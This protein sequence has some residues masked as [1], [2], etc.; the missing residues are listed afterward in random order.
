M[1]AATI[2]WRAIAGALGT[3]PVLAWALLLLT[4]VVGGGCGRPEP[5]TS[6]TAPAPAAATARPRLVSLAPNLTEIVC[7]VG[8]ADQLVGRTS[9]CDYPPETVKAIP[10][11]GDFG[12]PSLERLVQVKP[13]LVLDVALADEATGRRIAQL[14]ITH[15]RITCRSLGDVPRAIRE[16]G[17][18]TGHQA[19]AERLAG[20][21]VAA[22]ARLQQQLPP[23]DQRP[24]V[25]AEIWSDPLM[26][27]GK[28]ALVSELI[29][30]AGGVNLGDEVEKDYFEVSS[31]WVIARNPEVVFCFYESP[32]ADSPAAR[33]AQRGGWA[34]IR[35]VKS[36]RVFD[37]FD[38]NLVLK[39]GP[40]VLEA[41]PKLQACLLSVPPSPAGS[42]RR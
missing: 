23:P 39:P 37:G 17:R 31:E 3:R 15:K 9:V 5:G 30:L 32:S 33:V 18:L 27:P 40:R 4:S 25:F 34:G 28:G 13:T 41:V 7:A 35:A 6:A 2:I 20:G 14:G 1:T 36:R 11:V 29:A 12:A 16:V 42:P 38:I 24:R 26:T 22:M 21:M 10:V 19:E 8:A